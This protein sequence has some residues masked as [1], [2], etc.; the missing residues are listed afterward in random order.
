MNMF[1]IDAGQRTVIEDDNAGCSR[2]PPDEV[3]ALRVVFALNFIIIQEA[4]VLCRFSHILKY[5][6]VKLVK[7]LL[8]AHVLN[9]HIVRALSLVADWLSGGAICVD[10]MVR[11]RAVRR[12]KHV[13]E[14]AGSVRD[15]G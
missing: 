15:H 9:L 11:P 2:D 4:G 10:V 5:S 8:P 14:S 1:Q 3:D 6:T 12:S 13:V 7:L